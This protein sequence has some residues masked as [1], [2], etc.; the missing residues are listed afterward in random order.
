MTCITR[1]NG[2]IVLAIRDYLNDITATSVG[3]HLDGL[4]DQ[5]AGKILL[6]FTQVKG[7][8]YFGMA[9][10]MD[11]LLQYKKTRG[12]EI[13]FQGLSGECLQAAYYLGFE[14]I[15]GL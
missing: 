8:E 1:K 2:D 5:G 14:R 15:S 9:V 10:L 4:I 7:F 12:V 11:I 6:D 3:V 13:D